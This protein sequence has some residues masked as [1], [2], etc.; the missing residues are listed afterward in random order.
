MGGKH[1]G[2]LPYKSDGDAR[3]K[4]VGRMWVWFKLKVTPRGDF[5]VVCQGIYCKFLYAQ[6]LAIPERANVVTFPSKH[7]K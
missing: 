6:Y 3:R 2:G 4:I 1:P 7:P 5:C